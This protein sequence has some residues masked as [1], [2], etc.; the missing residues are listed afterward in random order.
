MKHITNTVYCRLHEIPISAIQKALDYNVT[1]NFAGLNK[2]DIVYLDSKNCIVILNDDPSFD[3]FSKF[4][5]KFL[6]F[7]RGQVVLSIYGTAD[8][9]YLSY[10]NAKRLG[11]S[12]Y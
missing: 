9:M 2:N 6:K 12:Y 10:Q 1:T 7:P 4:N 8:Y 11:G 5:K 3:I